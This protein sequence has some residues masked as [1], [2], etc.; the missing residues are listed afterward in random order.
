MDG[1]HCPVCEAPASRFFLRVDSRDYWR[2]PACEATFLDPARRPGRDAELAEYQLHRN[3]PDDAGYRQFLQR[4][5]A[6]LLERLAPARHGLDYG[7]GPVTELAVM[8]RDAGHDVAVY[9]PLFFD[10]PRVLTGRYDFVT[11]S[12]VAEH[13]HHPAEEFRRLDRLLA[14]G[15]W[16]ALMTNFQTDDGKFANWHYRRDPTHVVFYR[17]ATMHLLARRHGWSCEIPCRNVALMEKIGP[18]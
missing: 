9:D 13:F 6:P 12:E 17:E 5:A 2:C 7:C 16:L 8:L 10:D 3:D 14:P 15:G 4:L 18:R 11:C 1:M